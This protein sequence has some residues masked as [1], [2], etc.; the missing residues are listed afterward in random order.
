M[1]KL[2]KEYKQIILEK[3]WV[4]RLGVSDSLQPHGL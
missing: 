3:K 2:G 4:S 1:E